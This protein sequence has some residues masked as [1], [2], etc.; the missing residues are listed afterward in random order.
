MLAQT[1]NEDSLL[2]QLKSE[3]NNKEKGSILL[4]LA[5]SVDFSEREK[6]I[7]YYKQALEFLTDE[8]ER[9]E[10]LDTIGFY[11]WQLGNYE[12]AINYYSGAET[13]FVELKDSVWLGRVY[14][15]IGACYWGLG[16]L[17][18]ALIFYQKAAKIR[19]AINDYTGAAR[20][21]N[22]IGTVYQDWGMLEEG[23]K[24]NREALTYAQKEKN[25]YVLAFA[26]S[27]IGNYYEEIMD[28]DSALINYNTG[29]NYLLM[30]EEI[31]K[32]N[33][34]FDG[35][36]GNIYFKKGEL[37]SALFHYK[38]GLVYA[39]RVN[40]KNRLCIAEYNLAKT[41]FQ[42][43]KTDSAKFYANSSYNRAIE[44]NYMNFRMH[45][46]FLLSKISEKEKN[47]GKAYAFLK[48]AYELNDSLFNS[49]EIAK[50][51]NLQRL[52]SK[53]QHDREKEIL[54]KDIEIQKLTIQRQKHFRYV[55][56]ASIVVFLVIIFMI[57]R[58]SASLK[59]LNQKLKESEKE[60][61]IANA[62]KDKFFAI[63][64]HDL[65]S[66][67]NGLLGIT[68]LLSENY[69]ELSTNRKKVLVES[70]RESSS[71]VYALLESLLQWAQ[72][73]SGKIEY[74]F[75]HF[76]LSD[77]CN[78]VIELLKPNALNKNISIQ[79]NIDREL[80][81]Y[82]DVKAVETVFRNMISNS[83]KFS[84][85]GGS[86]TIDSKVV[87]DKIAVSIQ[88]T[89]VGMTEHVKNNLFRIDVNTSTKGTDNETGTGLG[90]ILCSELIA[91]HNG[92][93]EVKS[94]PGEGSTLI[95]TL[96][97]K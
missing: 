71:K 65:K 18:D 78:D 13:L 41:Y 76:N 1:S 73:Q 19:K 48:N 86:V 27:N 75:E 44:N 61:R 30:E 66:P 55:L 38:K 10:I 60:L 63:I 2:L 67:F 64:A 46:L 69:D 74:H 96:P 12:D 22:N 95:F 34:F 31:N 97:L 36:I 89:G 87:G 81:A 20:A 23:V 52:Y 43:N 62:N 57:I 28:Y 84:G 40:N 94:K 56:I 82:A 39:Y 35:F 47:I 24:F 9:A 93:I 17:N 8:H 6:S 53:E 83:V 14:N 29:Y 77:I 37:D 70:L 33:S 16:K 42:L 25:S 90:L 3:E 72:I 49:E 91:K 51:N 88:D 4:K 5:R 54:L 7:D 92:T 26:Y 59:K 80:K 79:N 15:T 32:S 11:N 85:N 45:N 21:L 58:S 68:N 50:F